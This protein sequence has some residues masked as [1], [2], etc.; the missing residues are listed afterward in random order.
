MPILI[1][2]DQLVFNFLDL[3]YLGLE[4]HCKVSAV[5]LLDEILELDL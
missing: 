1:G 5:V 3:L 2:V 4:R